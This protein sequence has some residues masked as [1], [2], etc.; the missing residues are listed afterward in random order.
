Q[1]HHRRLRQGSI[2]SASASPGGMG[3]SSSA[4]TARNQSRRSVLIATTGPTRSRP[5]TSARGGRRA[6]PGGG[7][8]RRAPRPRPR[9]R[10]RRPAPG[11]ARG[12]SLPAA[13]LV[14]LGLVEQGLGPARVGG[15][16]VGVHGREA[17]ADGEV[18]DLHGMLLLSVRR[19]GRCE[20]GPA[21]WLAWR[22]V[23][24]YYA[25]ARE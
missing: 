23:E 13:L 25:T 5:A 4:H 9:C 24:I 6:A 10:R 2:S 14:A 16:R 15:F 21:L 3:R 22:R 17:D 11:Q 7:G 19:A 1:A 18:G 12:R 8:P 20:G